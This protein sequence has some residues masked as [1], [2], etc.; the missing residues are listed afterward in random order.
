M[1]KHVR[2]KMWK[3]VYFQYF[4]FQKGLNSK[5]K[6]TEIDDTRT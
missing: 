6:M 4:K 5:K 1:S 2:G 3:T